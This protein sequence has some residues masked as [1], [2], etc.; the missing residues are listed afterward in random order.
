[1]NMVPVKRVKG[2]VL[3]LGRTTFAR[4]RPGN[5]EKSRCNGRGFQDGVKTSRACDP[6]A[7]AGAAPGVARVLV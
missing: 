6:R 7:T 1:L 2:K 3:L 5:P 4:F